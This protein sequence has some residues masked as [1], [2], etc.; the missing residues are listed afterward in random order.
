M[1]RP[2]ATGRL[3]D[4]RK[5][6]RTILILHQGVLHFLH[7]L[8]S[9]LRRHGHGCASISLGADISTDRWGGSG[10]I[11]KIGWATDGAVTVSAFT[12]G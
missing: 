1:G 2:Y 12:G 10:W 5:E 4:A 11:E 3:H 9:I 7:S 8:R 6:K